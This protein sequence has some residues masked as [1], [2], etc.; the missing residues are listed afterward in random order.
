[1]ILKFKQVYK[2]TIDEYKKCKWYQ[3]RRKRYLYLKAKRIHKDY[4]FYFN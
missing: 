2:D 4:E 3:F 1:M